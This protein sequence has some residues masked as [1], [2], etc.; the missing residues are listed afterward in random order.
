VIQQQLI[1]NDN[2]NKFQELGKKDICVNLSK[3]YCRGLFGGHVSI[4][5]AVNIITS[6]LEKRRDFTPQI[7]EQG[8]S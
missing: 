5:K 7:E 3:L 1:C 6:L 8:G 4:P 2:N